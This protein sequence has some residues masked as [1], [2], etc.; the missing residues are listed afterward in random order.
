M[1]LLGG[2]LT[3]FFLWFILILSLSIARVLSVIAWISC[4]IE[5]NGI[6]DSIA[7]GES[8][9]PITS[10]SFGIDLLFFTRILTK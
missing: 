4:L 2:R 10:Y 1:C 7:A 5:V 9:K 6:N 3:F 8:S